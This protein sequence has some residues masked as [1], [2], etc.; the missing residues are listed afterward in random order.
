VAETENRYYTGLQITR[1]PGVWVVYM[2]FLLMIGGCMV[3]FFMS[4]RRFCI[5]L[6]N[7]GNN[8][9]VMVQ[10]I[11]NKNRIGMQKK[12]DAVAEALSRFRE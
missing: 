10:G 11:V 8:T 1:D 5:E 3:S 7:D 9:S 2:G 12:I 4:H 6:K